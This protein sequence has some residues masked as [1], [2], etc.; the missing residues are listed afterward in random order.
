MCGLVGVLGDS[1]RW[2]TEMFEVM[3]QIDVIRGED[4][5]G[6]AA[7]SRNSIKVLKDEGPP[8]FL[9]ASKEYNEMVHSTQ[10]SWQNFCLIGHNRF[11]TKG[12]V[13]RENAHPF[14]HGHITLVHN[15]TLH[16]MNS[17]R[18][19]GQDKNFETDSEQIAYSISQ[20]GIDW[21]Y[22]RLYGAYALV[23]WDNKEKTLNMVT[24][25]QRPLQYGYSDN[26]KYLVWASRGW[27]ILGA[28][29]EAREKLEKNVWH[30]LGKDVLYTFSLEGKKITQKE[31][32][33]QCYVPVQSANQNRGFRVIDKR[34]WPGT[35]E[36]RQ[37]FLETEEAKPSPLQ[38]SITK[39]VKTTKPFS[40]FDSAEK[41]FTFSRIKDMTETEFL[42]IYKKCAFCE[43]SLENEYDE[44]VILDDHHAVCNSCSTVGELEGLNLHAMKGI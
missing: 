22:P 28:M 39:N 18:V 3:L 36:Q 37:K 19:P 15:G 4:S 23:F 35:H 26:G 27:M 30:P 25:G 41:K 29:T 31:R 2:M 14:R 44:S 5:T 6:V 24:N 11:A 13:S 17:I 21:V 10:A 20:K 42:S 16:Q 38:K 33:L 32:K 1:G 40:L 8:C 7:I 9:M 12:K 43:D 34:C